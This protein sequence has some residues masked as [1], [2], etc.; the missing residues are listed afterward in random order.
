MAY[1]YKIYPEHDLVAVPFFGHTTGREIISLAHDL[2]CQPAWRKGMDRVYDYRAIAGAAIELDDV[3]EA[4]HV[5]GAIQYETSGEGEGRPI[6]ARRVI[7]VDD[8]RHGAVFTLYGFLARQRGVDVTIV[9][10]AEMA[11]E[12]LGLAGTVDLPAM[13]EA[14]RPGDACGIVEPDS[15][16]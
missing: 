12:V 15:V 9:P 1:V 10:T 16:R 11:A 6:P 5:F 2:T 4:V 14:I 8:D 3:K 7:I 13:L